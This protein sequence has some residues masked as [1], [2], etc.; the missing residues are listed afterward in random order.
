[1]DVDHVPSLHHS[2]DMLE[3]TPRERSE[4]KTKTVKLWNSAGFCMFLTA[5]ARSDG[6]TEVKYSGY[7]SATGQLGKIRPALA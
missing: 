3:T 7:P 6:V 4:V 1:M 5:D 2:R